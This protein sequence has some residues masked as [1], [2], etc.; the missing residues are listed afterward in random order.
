MSGED[1]KHFLD[2]NAVVQPVH[3]H[4]YSHKP[5]LVSFPACDLDVDLAFLHK[6]DP[7]F[8]GEVIVQSTHIG[9]KT[10]GQQVSVGCTA[11]TPEERSKCSAYCLI[12]KS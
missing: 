8:K 9:R 6:L 3:G 5:E 12:Y 2:G 7:K 11:V 4:S 10:T 1:C